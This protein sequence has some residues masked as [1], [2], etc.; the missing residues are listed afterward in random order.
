MSEVPQITT[1]YVD[2]RPSETRDMTAE[3]IAQL[4]PEG[5]IVENIQKSE[6]P[7]E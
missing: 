1:H 2:G 4:L 7:P 3:E 6:S 5:F